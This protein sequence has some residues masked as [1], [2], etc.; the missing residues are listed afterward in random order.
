VLTGTGETGR[1]T[2]SGRGALG[3]EAFLGGIF[4]KPPHLKSGVGLSF[5]IVKESE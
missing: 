5:N 1:G 2:D 4:A 3:P